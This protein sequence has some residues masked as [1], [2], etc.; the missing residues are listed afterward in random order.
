VNKFAIKLFKE[1]ISK[2]KKTISKLVVKNR[3]LFKVD[4]R[5]VYYG[6]ILFHP[7]QWKTGGRVTAE[8]KAEGDFVTVR[9]NNGAVPI[10][11]V[12]ELCWNEQAI[13]DR[14]CSMCGQEKNK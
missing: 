14:Y 8:Y 11:R 12:D 3:E 10:V 6:N 7:N 1:E 5:P 9:S 4:G 2:L 13:P